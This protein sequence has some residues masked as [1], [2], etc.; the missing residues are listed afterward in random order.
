MRYVFRVNDP[1]AYFEFYCT[2]KYVLRVDRKLY[3]ELYCVFSGFFFKFFF[4]T[5]NLVA[6]IF[7]ISFFLTIYLV[8]CLILVSML[9][10][11]QSDI[12]PIKTY[13]LSKL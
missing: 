5:R 4:I 8:C 11:C 10:L 6:Q 7:Y 2:S 1:K 13:H 3:F 9:D 12:G